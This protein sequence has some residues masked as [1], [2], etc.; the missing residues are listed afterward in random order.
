[1]HFEEE[2]KYPKICTKSSTKKKQFRSL[3]VYIVERFKPLVGAYKN[4]L[5]WSPCRIWAF[6]GVKFISVVGCVLVL[7]TVIGNFSQ[8][9]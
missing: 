9:G 2:T 6:G 5:V 8:I 1:M 4:D 3:L 7:K